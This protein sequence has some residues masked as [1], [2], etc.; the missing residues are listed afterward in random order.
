M[1]EKEEKL[2]TKIQICFHRTWESPVLVAINHSGHCQ[3]WKGMS[4]IS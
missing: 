2:K 1:T 3:S 4:G